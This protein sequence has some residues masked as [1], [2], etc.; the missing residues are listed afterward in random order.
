MVATTCVSVA[1]AHE[2]PAGIDRLDTFGIW[3]DGITHTF[4][5]VL[6]GENVGTPWVDS[7]HVVNM[8]NNR[9]QG[10]VLNLGNS[11][12]A[13]GPGVDNVTAYDISVTEPTDGQCFV[14]WRDTYHVI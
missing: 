12:S 2:I 13:P 5:M 3:S 14:L 9:R 10:F 11:T 7:G 4:Q 6:N 1:V 8:T